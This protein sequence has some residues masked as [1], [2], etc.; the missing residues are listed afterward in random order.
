MHPRVVQ[1]ELLDLLPPE[2]PAARHSRR[3]LRLTNRIMGN[4]RWLAAALRAQVRPGERVL[5]L[6]AG[7][8]ELALGLARRGVA[9]DGLDRCPAPAGW[10]GHARWHRAD[11]R[12]FAGWRD[13]DVVC[14]NL[15][16]HQFPAGEL[17]DLGTK[18]HL[19]ARLLVACEPA[20]WRR[21]RWL[22]G[23]LAPAFGASHVT[24]HDGRVSIAAGFLDDELPQLLGL[25]PARWAWHRTTTRLGAY[26]LVAWRREAS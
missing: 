9:V 1:P 24:R 25:D 26:Q 7:T 14:G 23:L 15:I 22:F 11:L 16:F 2:H 18:I 5:E 20:R 8:G 6:G 3:D 4:H 21:S 12:T 17:F 13:Y 19:H 10:P